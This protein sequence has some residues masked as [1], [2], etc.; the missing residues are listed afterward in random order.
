MSAG[1]CVLWNWLTCL[2]GLENMKF[3]RQA[4]P[5]RIDVVVWNLKF[6]GQASRLET[7]VSF[8]VT[9]SRHNSFSGNSSALWSSMD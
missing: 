8:C 1:S 9:V 4:Q 2:W 5:G 7:Q 3:V 6:T